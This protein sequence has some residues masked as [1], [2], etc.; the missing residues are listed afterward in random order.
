MLQRLCDRCGAVA[1]AASDPSLTRKTLTI[2]QGDPST[3][4]V[5]AD[6]EITIGIAITPQDLCGVCQA[7]ALVEYALESLRAHLT[8]DVL[9]ALSARINVVTGFKP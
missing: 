3:N 1:E 8:A 7:S 5:A 9:T 4:P 2:P 6:S